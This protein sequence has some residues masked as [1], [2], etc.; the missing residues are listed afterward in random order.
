MMLS[1]VEKCVINL[2]SLTLNI[3]NPVVLKLNVTLRHSHSRLLF[4]YDLQKI[5]C[6]DKRCVLFD[7]TIP[8]TNAVPYAQCRSHFTTWPLGRHVTADYR[9]L[10]T[11][12]SA[13]R[14]KVRIP[15]VLKIGQIQTLKWWTQGKRDNKGARVRIAWWSHMNYV[16]SLSSRRKVVLKVSGH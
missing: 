16:Y 9:N 7:D 8:R 13:S 14:Q 3:P 10:T 6:T 5:N 15:S 11:A 4:F 1:L 2:P 12:T